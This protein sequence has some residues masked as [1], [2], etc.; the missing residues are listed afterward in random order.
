MLSEVML[1]TIN[2]RIKAVRKDA[3]LSQTAFAE[4]LGATRGVI[5]NIEGN[6][7]TP[8]NSFVSLICREFGVSLAW[9]ETGEGEMYV[10][11]SVN[12][13][14]ALMV[15]DLMGDADE[16]F[17]KRFVSALLAL[18]PESWGRIEQFVQSL[19][20]GQKNTEGE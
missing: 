10:R 15:A 19:S 2:E 4:R 18:P 20:A 1:M 13:E 14:L 12:E 6:L 7:T 17:R 11:R 8:N 5:T 3:R 16:S 9:L